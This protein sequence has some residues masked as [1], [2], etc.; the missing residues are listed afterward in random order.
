[1]KMKGVQFYSN[2]KIWYGSYNGNEIAGTID[3]GTKSPPK[4]FAK[5]VEREIKKIRPRYEKQYKKV[6]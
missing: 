6:I 1:M 2:G 3:T 4:W 5:M